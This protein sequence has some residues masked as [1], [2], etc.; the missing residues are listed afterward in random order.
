MNETPRLD[1]LRLLTA[2][3]AVLALLVIAGCGDDGDST[4]SSTDAGSTTSVPQTGAA[5]SELLANET[6]DCLEGEGLDPSVG[7]GE[8]PDSA[9]IDLTTQ[10][11]TIVVQV[12]PSEDEA[13]AYKS[14]S[15]L[16]QEQVG[17]AVILGGLVPADTRQSIIDC[18]PSL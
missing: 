5:D 14:A 9:S 4:S 18:L 17:Y 7:P 15:G 8:E 3:A 10:N 1:A 13:A 12:F 16:D 6:A 11:R 2:A